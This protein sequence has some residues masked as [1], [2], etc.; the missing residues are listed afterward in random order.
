MDNNPR[1][2]SGQEAFS[3]CLYVSLCHTGWSC[4]ARS[5]SHSSGSNQKGSSAQ[6]CLAHSALCCRLCWQQELGQ[7]SVASRA[8]SEQLCLVWQGQSL[9]RSW[10]SARQVLLLSGQASTALWLPALVMVLSRDCFTL[11]GTWSPLLLIPLMPHQ[12]LSPS[13]GAL[14]ALEIA[15]LRKALGHHT[16]AGELCCWLCQHQSCSPQYMSERRTVKLVPTY[17]I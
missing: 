2:V 4:S 9:E 15:L 14:A 16:G 7:Q 6:E 17:L 8:L 12:P 3:P 11:V 10:P 5:S 13:C 1:P